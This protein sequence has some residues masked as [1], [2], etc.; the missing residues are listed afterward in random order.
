MTSRRRRVWRVSDFARHVFGEATPATKIRARRL[1]LRLDAKHGGKLLHASGG[2]NRGWWFYPA[3]L[4]ELEATLFAPLE[5]LGP[6][7]ED[8]EETVTESFERLAVDQKIIATQTARN[9]RD[10]ARLRGRG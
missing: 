10:I 2:T 5:S 1:L 8:L 7:L 4:A 6:R 9:S 3:T